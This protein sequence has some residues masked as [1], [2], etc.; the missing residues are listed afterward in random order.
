MKLHHLDR[1]Q[2]VGRELPEVFEFFARAENLE[3]ITPPWLKFRIL[4]PVP[5]AMRVGA[6]IEYR[7]RVH[8]LPMTWVS[9]IDRWEH[10][11]QFVDQQLRGPYRF[12]RHRHQFH[13]V[14]GGTRVRDRVE[15]ALPLGGVGD[16]LGTPLVRRDL[17][18]IF[19]YRRA[20]VAELL[21]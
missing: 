13:E 14:D 6:R 7:L 19:E 16:L 3:L 5:V 10:G 18:R 8:G 12:W 9:V 1:E 20:R 2:V 4:T 17:D 11:E 21:G 15:Y